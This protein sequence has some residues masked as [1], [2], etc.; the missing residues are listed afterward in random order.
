MKG[1]L[2]RFKKWI[3]GKGLE[4]NAK[5][6][7]IMM[8]RKRVGRKMKM[9]FKWNNEELE[10]MKKFEYLGYTMM[11]NNSETEHIKRIKGKANS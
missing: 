8:F 1:M 9:T 5:K 10:M 3:E 11:E 6:A 7:K 4:L 2:K